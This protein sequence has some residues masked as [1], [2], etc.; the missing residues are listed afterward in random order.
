MKKQELQITRNRYNDAFVTYEIACA[1]KTA[2][3]PQENPYHTEAFINGRLMDTMRVDVWML[4][5]PVNNIVFCPTV[6]NALKW[7]CEKNRIYPKIGMTIDNGCNVL[8]TADLFHVPDIE[9]CDQG[10]PI[11]YATITPNKR[12][13]CNEQGYNLFCSDVDVLLMDIIAYLLELDTYHVIEK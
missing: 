4:A 3:F 13:H 7:L 11:E 8:Y 9:E 12:W 2:G 10:W 5:N 1:L 6:S